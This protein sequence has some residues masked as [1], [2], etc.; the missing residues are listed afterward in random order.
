MTDYSHKYDLKTIPAI[1]TQFMLYFG[2][3][4][5]RHHGFTTAASLSYTTL[6]SIVPLITVMFGL[7]EKLS[8]RIDTTE[9]IQQFIFTNFVPAVGGT[10]LGYVSGFSTK[11][12]E[13]AAPGIGL[14]III[15]LMLMVTIDNAINS[16]WTERESRRMPA[17]I[18]IYFLILILGP[19]LMGYGLAS[20][21]YLLS[22]EAINDIDSG[23]HIRSELLHWLPYISTSLLLTLV[24]ILVPNYSI[25]KL[26]ALLSGIFSATL[27]E[28]AKI[29]FGLYI[30]AMYDYQIIYGAIAVILIFLTWIYI[31]WVIVL[32]GAHLTFC[33]STFRK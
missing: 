18:L 10:V 25:S 13:L 12:S 7:L 28:V 3:N 14:L 26:D 4:F 17:R 11:A 9:A 21:S 8:I 6:L 29:S 24:Y 2:K 31:S 15:S 32:A 20:T 1:V 30:T 22:L 23:L 5:Y 33:L 27:F 19:L 16:I